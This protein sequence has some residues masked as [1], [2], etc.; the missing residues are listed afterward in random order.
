MASISF[1][2]AS[3][4]ADTHNHT[5]TAL[6]VARVAAIVACIGLMYSP[7][8]SN[9]AIL[10]TFVATL[11]LPDLRSRWN[12]AISHP[13]GWLAWLFIGIVFI[14]CFVGEARPWQHTASEFWSWRK[15]AWFFLVLM[16]F[17]D[18]AWKRKLSVWFV[19]GSVPGVL[20]T[21]VGVSGLV[22]LPVEADKILRNTGTQGV[23]LAVAALVCFWW[24]LQTGLTA[25]Q[26]TLWALG[27]IIFAANVM[28]VS[29]ARAGYLGLVVSVVV[30]GAF[31]LS[32][33]QWAG[34]VVAVCIAV[35]TVFYTSDR[36]QDRVMKGVN[37]WRAAEVSIEPG[38]LGMRYIFYKHSLAIIDGNWLLGSGTGSFNGAYIQQVKSMNYPEGNWR[39]MFT[40]D[41]HNQ[42]IHTW[43]D[44]GLLGLVVFVAWIA[45]VVTQRRSAPPFRALAAGMVLAWTAASMFNGHFRSFAEGHLLA[46]FAGAMVAANPRRLVK[47]P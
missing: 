34:L 21:F 46:T 11:F 20:L 3:S 35:P 6:R 36:M 39:N 27:F 42:F 1:E 32:R 9:L 2:A 8:V 14:W 13:A 23:S 26:R 15:L 29:V 28:T 25:R 47:P 40:D 18:D 33:R 7:P 44:Q 45:A 30:V 31:Q 17:D 24:M 10:A 12:A 38:S 5:S 43:I 4:T 37:E 41:P 16:L 22:V 19:V